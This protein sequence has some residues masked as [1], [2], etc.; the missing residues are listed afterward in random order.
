MMKKSIENTDLKKFY[1]EF[2]KEEKN[3]IYTDTCTKNGIQ[4][5]CIN[6]ELDKTLTH[7]FSID[8]DSG[9]VTN[10]KQS[11]RCWMFAATNVF[12]IEVMKNLNL[13]DFELSQSYPLFYDK[14]EKSNFFLE[15][16]LSTLDESTS[17]RLI[18]FLLTAPVNDG[19]Q[20]DMFVSLT[21]KY[22]VVPKQVMPET[23]NSSNTRAFDRYLTLKLREY[24]CELRTE[25]QKGATI[26]ELRK[27]KEQMLSTIYRMLV[28]SLGKPPVTF[29]FETRDKD[30]KFIR[31]ENIT[32]QEFY[33]KYVKLN[34]DDFISVI[35]APT[36]DKPFHHSFTVKYLGN[37][38]GGRQVKYLNLPIEDLKRLAIAQLTDGQTVWFG[39]DVGQFSTRDTGF[40]ALDSYHADKLFST[41]FPMDKAQ[42]LDY[43][44]SL[45]TH[46]MVFTGVRHFRH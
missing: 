11:G 6:T 36:K 4:E 35:N 37:V 28:I 7:N 39:S 12:R 32:P 9:K 22:G 13:K 45:M 1:K 19:G 27:L 42:R 18:S 10:Q 20:W 33:E 14:L 43:G 21:K 30:N 34:L 16:I 8:I 2:T 17:S 44:E 15:N 41:T 31:I 40:L 29:T 26:A 25:H 24:A 46:A 5:S 23:A 3:L 38:V